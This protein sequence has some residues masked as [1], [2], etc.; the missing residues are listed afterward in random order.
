MIT[1]KIYKTTFVDDGGKLH[2]LI[3]VKRNKGKFKT[4]RWN[5]E[6]ANAYFISNEKYKFIRIEEDYKEN[7]EEKDNQQLYLF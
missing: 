2:K 4:E 7:E 1:V 5:E 3:R 6:F